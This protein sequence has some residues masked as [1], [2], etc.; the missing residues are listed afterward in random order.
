M[1]IHEIKNTPDH[2]ELL[3]WHSRFGLCNRLTEHGYADVD[4]PPVMSATK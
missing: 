2:P 1:D 4:T 3:S